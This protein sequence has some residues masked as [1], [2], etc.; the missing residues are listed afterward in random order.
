MIT[1]PNTISGLSGS[2]TKLYRTLLARLIKKRRRNR[3]RTKY[4]NGRNEL[5]DIGYALPPV[6]SDIDIVVGWPAK[7][8]EGLANRVVLDGLA[9]DDGGELDDLVT[10]VVSENDLVGM[11]DSVHTDAFVHSCSFVAVLNGDPDM[12]EPEVI[13]QEFTAD[14]ATGIWDKRRHRLSS[15]LLFDV[16]DDYETVT[17]AYLMTYGMTIIMQDDGNGWHVAERSETD[18]ERIAC[19]LFAFKPDE[20]RPFGRSRI[21]RTVMSLTDSA[22]RTFLRSELQAELYSV[23]PR[24]FL[25]ASEDM[26]TDEDGNL[27]PKWRLM[28]D[29]AL[30]LPRDPASGEVPQVGQFAQ[31]SFEP[32]SAQLRQTATMFASATSLPPDAMGVLTDNPSS[33]EA[34]D[35]ATKELCLLAE[36]C[37]RWFG[38]SWRHVLDRA[39]Q[40]AGSAGQ[41]QAVRPQWRN[42]AT[43]SRAAAADA[44][45]KLVQ[46]KILPADSEVTYDMLDLSDEQRRVL[47]M[48]RQTKR[49]EERIDQ[50]RIERQTRQGVGGDVTQQPADSSGEPQALTGGT[51]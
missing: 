42:P 50:L 31:Y 21:D 13:I 2:E 22:V 4:M 26:F 24:Y 5:H 33:A 16:S 35:K 20:Q 41:V 7:A 47:H 3:L 45:I 30:I 34:I 11:A 8:V 51:R 9:G 46:A 43:P 27:I 17:S 29:Q 49:A 39:Q 19:E 48:E 37:Q 23:P 32:H 1:F 15:A 18:D 28:L 6:A 44:A 10:S 25:G 40:A 12:G 14:V 38:R 36:K